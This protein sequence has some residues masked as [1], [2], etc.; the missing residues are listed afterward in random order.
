MTHQDATFFTAADGVTH[1]YVLVAGCRIHCAMAGDGP[2]VLLIP[3][4]PQTW[5]TWRHVMKALAQAGFTQVSSERDLAGIERCS[6]GRWPGPGTIPA[7]RQV[8]GPNP[9]NPA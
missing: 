1:Q 2:P 4:W 6:G 3:G 5:F 7:T 9:D 8:F